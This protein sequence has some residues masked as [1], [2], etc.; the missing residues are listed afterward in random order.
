M[1][2]RPL[3]RRRNGA[4][5]AFT[6]IELMVVVAI[7]G[8]VMTM[9]LPSVYRQLHPNSMK[10]AVDDILEGCSHARAQAI[11]HGSPTE[12]RIRPFDRTLEVSGSRSSGPDDGG[13]PRRGGQ[14]FNKRFSDQIS[15]EMLDVNF[16]DYREEEVAAIRFQENGVSDEFTIVLN[17]D[18]AEWRMITLEVVT[19]LAEVFSDPLDPRVTRIINRK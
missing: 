12:L 18:K 16:L 6:L 14:A 4:A 7:I 19:G 3:Q 17:N 13:G 5:N 15:I 2:Y 11:L 1:T 9:A 10:Q 8:I